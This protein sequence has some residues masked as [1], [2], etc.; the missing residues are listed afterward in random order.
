MKSIGALPLG[1]LSADNQ[2]ECLADGMTDALITNL[3]K[4]RA[5]RVISRQSIVRYKGSTK[6]LPE[7][8]REHKRRRDRRGCGPTCVQPRASSRLNAACTVR[9]PPVRGEL[10]AGRK[11]FA[12]LAGDVA[13]A[14]GREIKA[15]VTPEEMTRLAWTPQANPEA[16]RPT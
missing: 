10:R 5:V 15:A 4:I 6:P 13:R 11:G 8:A 12:G 9:P 1:S 14:V 3:G 2:Y 7:I 16:T